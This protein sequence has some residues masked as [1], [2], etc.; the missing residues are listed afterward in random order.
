MPPQP[1]Q[2]QQQHV[3]AKPRHYYA[4]QYVPPTLPIGATNTIFPPVWPNGEPR[5]EIPG[6]GTVRLTPGMWVLSSRYSGQVLEVVSDEE[7][8]ERFGA[9]S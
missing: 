5:V 1:P 7:Y 3:V 8:Q 2:G 6:N 9:P 4:E